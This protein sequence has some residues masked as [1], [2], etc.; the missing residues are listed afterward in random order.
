MDNRYDDVVKRIMDETQCMS[1][2]DNAELLLYAKEMA[3][4]ITAERD[5]EIAS[6]LPVPYTK[7]VPAR[8]QLDGDTLLIP[9]AITATATKMPNGDWIT[10]TKGPRMGRLKAECAVGVATELDMPGVVTIIRV[11]ILWRREK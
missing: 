11:V 5:A 2:S 4:G 7:R 1:T 9:R 8:A 6:E 10:S 3:E